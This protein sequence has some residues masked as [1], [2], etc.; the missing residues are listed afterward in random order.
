MLFV[1]L[2]LL[3]LRSALFLLLLVTVSI[4]FLVKVPRSSLRILRVP[5]I[6]PSPEHPSPLKKPTSVSPRTLQLK[7]PSFSDL[8]IPVWV[9]PRLQHRGVVLQVFVQ[10]SDKNNRWLMF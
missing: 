6:T 10:R 8:W 5:P 9:A 2:F 1:S 7:R 3:F 4:L